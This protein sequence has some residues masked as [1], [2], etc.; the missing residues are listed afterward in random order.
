MSRQRA[1]AD[2][3]AFASGHF[4]NQVRI[5]RHWG[6]EIAD[7]EIADNPRFNTTRITVDRNY[8]ANAVDIVMR[9]VVDSSFFV[10]AA[11]IASTDTIAPIENFAISWDSG[12]CSNDAIA[13]VVGAPVNAPGAVSLFGLDFA[14][15][16]LMHTRRRRA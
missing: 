3:G 1:G 16:T 11:H 7:N 5:G 15:L 6:D 14:I 4:A 12:D 13:G 9:T 8:T 2:Y 10:V